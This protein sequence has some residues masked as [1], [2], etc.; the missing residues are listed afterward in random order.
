[1][2][3]PSK[4]SGNGRK[5]GNAVHG[6]LGHIFGQSTRKSDLDADWNSVEPVVLHRIIWAV[7]FLGGSVTFGSTRNGSA[8]TIKVYLGAPY[9]PV[10]FDGD[11]EGRAGMSAFADQLV[12][13][14]A[15]A[16]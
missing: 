15:N 10:Y 16:V 6:S 2:P 14:A 8:Y 3:T 12:E 1:M 5:S 13:A 9:D 11:D 7:D 4:K